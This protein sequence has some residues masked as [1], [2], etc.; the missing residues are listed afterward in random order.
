MSRSATGLLL[1][2]QDPASEGVTLEDP[3]LG[4][5]AAL[6]ASQYWGHAETFAL[7]FT[8]LALLIMYCVRCG[9]RPATAGTS[10]D[11]ES[12][13]AAGTLEAPPGMCAFLATTPFWGCTCW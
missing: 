2:V 6:S 4:A 12:S 1:C 5:L 8:S 3:A 11:L 7:L 13:G 9:Y 10:A